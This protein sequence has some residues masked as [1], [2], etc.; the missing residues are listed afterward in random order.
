MSGVSLAVLRTCGLGLA[1]AGHGRK[2]YNIQSG[3]CLKYVWDAD[4]FPLGSKSF[5]NALF[6]MNEVVSR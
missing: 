5:R 2:M 3:E 4:V 1:S 6:S